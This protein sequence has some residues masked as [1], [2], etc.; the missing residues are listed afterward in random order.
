MSILVRGCFDP[1]SVSIQ[2][3]DSDR[4]NAGP[5]VGPARDHLQAG[6]LVARTTT[7]VER[8]IRLP[9][10]LIARVN[11][12]AEA[13]GRSANSYIERVLEAAV[14]P[15]ASQMTLDGAVAS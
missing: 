5:T 12:A 3:I 2:R 9:E 1:E 10:D 14:P 13:E 4:W 7:R 6:G 15:I 11:A 8:T